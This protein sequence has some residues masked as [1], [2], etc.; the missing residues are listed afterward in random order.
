MWLRER[1]HVQIIDG[2]DI[3]KDMLSY[4]R[5]KSIYRHLFQENILSTSLPANSYSLVISSLAVCHVKELDKLYLEVNRILEPGGYF[6]LVDYHPFF[7]LNG[8]PTHFPNTD[9]KQIAIENWL[10]LI[11]DYISKGI[12]QRFQLLE[13]KERIVTEEWAKRAPAMAKY[14]MLPV[15]FVLVWKKPL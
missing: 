3:T 11:S 5:E 7:L 2:V 10:H 9:G 14:I 1:R 4:A 6:I 15:S 8:I 12:N 13:M